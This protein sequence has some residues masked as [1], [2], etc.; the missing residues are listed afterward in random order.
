MKNFALLSITWGVSRG[1][2]TEGW[3]ICTLTNG[4]TGKKYTTKG[5][6]YDMKGTVF[7]DYLQDVHKD[8]LL[9][10]K[11]RFHTYD[12]EQRTINN[13]PDN[14]TGGTYYIKENRITLD[15]AYRITLD[16]AYGLEGMIR[17]AEACGLEIWPNY[18]KG[19]LTAIVVLEDVPS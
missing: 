8:K 11:D 4:R 3:N 12:G 18:I 6:G 2:N 17:I 16:G 9:Q 15:G 13:N 5:G 1:R 7:A 14:L 19:R 10:L